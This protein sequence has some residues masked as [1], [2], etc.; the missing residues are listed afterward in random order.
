MRY[1]WRRL[2]SKKP[3]PPFRKPRS[4]RII[5]TKFAGRIYILVSTLLGVIAV[6][7]GNNLLYLTTAAL[8]GYM[9]ASGVAGRKNIA[10]LSVTVEFSGDVYAGTPCSAVVR[11][12]NKNRSLPVFWI[13]ATLWNGGEASSV[14]FPIIQ[15]GKTESKALLTTFPQRGLQKIDDL[16]LCSTYPFNFFERFWPVVFETDVTVFPCPLPCDP[17][18]ALAARTDGEREGQTVVP[19]LETEIVGVRPYAE[20]DP[21]KRVH[22]K[23]S[24]RTGKLQTRLYEGAARDIRMI[25]L[26]RLLAGGTERGLSQATFLVLESLKAGAAIGLRHRDTHILPTSGRTHARTLLTRLALYGY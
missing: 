11:V 3:A 1:S 2:F 22:W 10:R 12:T 14:F 24:A 16:D 6:N 20:G 5:R 8:L 15:P 7:S 23:S 9:L 17:A 4:A 26:D 21:M 25:D 18:V 19:L 13:E